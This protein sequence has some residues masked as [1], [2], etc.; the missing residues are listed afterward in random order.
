[1]NGTMFVERIPRIVIVFVFALAKIALAEAEPTCP[2]FASV[3]RVD[4]IPF[5][6]DKAGSVVDPEAQHQN[7]AIQAPILKM[8]LYI[9]TALDSKDGR[10]PSTDCAFAIIEGW[11]ESRAMTERPK[12]FEGSVRRQGYTIGLNVVAL[13]LKSLG[14]LVTDPMRLWLRGLVNSIT[15]M[16]RE[17]N[18]RN[19]LYA[20]SGVATASYALIAPYPRAIEYENKVWRDSIAEITADGFL[21]KELTRSH[22]ALIYHQYAFSALLMLRQ[23]RLALGDSESAGDRAALQRLADRISSNLCDPR[24]M[25]AASGATQEMPDQ[26]AYRVPDTFGDGLLDASWAK[27]GITPPHFNDVNLGGRLDLTARLLERLAADHPR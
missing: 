24:Q 23:M 6:A 25:T 8:L 13:K 20:W 10:S 17:N 19:N 14:Y 12:T 21:P 7:E 18:L 27:C 4:G 16:Y 22:R 26:T 2:S 5:Y 15:D 1:M 9:E 3:S 11:A